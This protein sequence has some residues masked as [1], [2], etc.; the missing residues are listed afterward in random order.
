MRP[1][2]FTQ[3][4]EVFVGNCSTS[5]HSPSKIMETMG[6]HMLETFEL[7]LDVTSGVK[8]EERIAEVRDFQGPSNF[9]LVHVILQPLP[10]SFLND[11]REIQV[12]IECSTPIKL[13]GMGC[14][15][16]S[17]YNEAM[18]QDLIE[19]TMTTNSRLGRVRYPLSSSYQLSHSSFDSSPNPSPSHS[20][21]A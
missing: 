14:R 9:T 15:W 18:T 2:S 10:S 11:P 7:F 12:V 4:Q 6:W 1:C 3:V 19:K 5:A 16:I 20:S 8:V 21:C 17:P 13:H